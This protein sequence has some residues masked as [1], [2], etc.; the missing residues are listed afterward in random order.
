MSCLL[1]AY[2]SSCLVCPLSCGVFVVSS[3][4]GGQTQLTRYRA[5]RG[6]QWSPDDL[7]KVDQ[8]VTS[9]TPVQ[10]IDAGVVGITDSGTLY[11]WYVRVLINRHRLIILQS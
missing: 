4:R 11:I 2:L 7:E 1:S 5:L 9:L 8:Q 10:G 6:D 3:C